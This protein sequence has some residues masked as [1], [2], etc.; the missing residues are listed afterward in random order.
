MEV[1]WGKYGQFI[2]C[3]GY[4]E[5]RNSRPY[6]QT[7]RN[8]STKPVRPA[9]DA[10]LL[11]IFAPQPTTEMD[12]S[13]KIILAAMRSNASRGVIKAG[14]VV[15]PTGQVMES[16]WDELPQMKRRGSGQSIEQWDAVR[17]LKPDQVIKFPCIWKHR[18]ANNKGCSS[19]TTI[20]KILRKRGWEGIY[21]CKDGIVYVGRYP[22]EV[23]NAKA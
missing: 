9:R 7:S 15:E 14:Q 3:S 11:G 13:S 19:F 4:P 12:S 18:H 21:N 23:N 8:T 10:D 17:A 22:K 16:S 5:C 2:A 6:R 20:R 1:K